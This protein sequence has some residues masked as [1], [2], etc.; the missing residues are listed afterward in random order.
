MFGLLLEITSVIRYVYFW[1]TG[2]CG[3]RSISCSERALFAVSETNIR[4]HPLFIF[5]KTGNWPKFCIF[6][7]FN[8]PIIR[9]LWAHH[10][11]CS[12]FDTVTDVPLYFVLL[13]SN[14]NSEHSDLKCRKVQVQNRANLGPDPLEGYVLSGFWPF[15]AH[16]D[17][18]RSL[19]LITT[20]TFNFQKQNFH[21]TFLIC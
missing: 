13:N 19:F 10:L 21:W 16:R 14:R 4:G 1:L 8:L 15:W 2:W 11:C 6:S 7:S 3:V 12:W 17:K 9:S 20:L 5:G 18:I